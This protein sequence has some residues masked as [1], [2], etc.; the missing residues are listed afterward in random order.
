M[1]TAKTI[2]S[3]DEEGGVVPQ[4]KETAEP[5]LN[6]KECSLNKE[7]TNMFDLADLIC[8]RLNLFAIMNPNL[9]VWQSTCTRRSLLQMDCAS[10]R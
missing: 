3:M 5:S 2:E 6:I 9:I 10:T 8:Q 1:E 7:G 4:H